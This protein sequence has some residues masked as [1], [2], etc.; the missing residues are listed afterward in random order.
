MEAA[1]A[2]CFFTASGLDP[3][4]KEPELSEID[5]CVGIKE[6]NPDCDFGP[7]DANDARRIALPL[8]GL[9]A[10][11]EGCEPFLSLHGENEFACIAYSEGLEIE[12]SVGN[13]HARFE[14]G[15]QEPGLAR[16]PRL[17]STN[18]VQVRQEEVQRLRPDDRTY[19]H[20]RNAEVAPLPARPG[21][22]AH[23]RVARVAGAGELRLEDAKAGRALCAL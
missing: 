21:L 3:S 10:I 4:E 15:I 5:S 14:R 1:Y 9:S 13:R 20:L 8:G 22:P 23:S 17:I 2:S 19:Q 18:A 12:S 16:A 7:I 11:V 6:P